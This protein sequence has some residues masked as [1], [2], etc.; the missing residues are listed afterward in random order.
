MIGSGARLSGRYP[1]VHTD[2]GIADDETLRR[3]RS[4]DADAIATLW[5]I[6]QPQVLRLLRAK[7]AIAPEDIAS[8]VWL[9][10]GRGLDR[11]RGDGTAF[12]R[13]VFTLTSRRA[14][15]ESRRR[16]RRGEISADLSGDDWCA[17]HAED[18]FD[19]GGALDRALT[20]LRRLKPATAEVV[21]LRVVHELPVAE[22]ARIT[23]RSEG[24]VRT[25]VH[26]GLGEL[27]SLCGA[28]A[29]EMIRPA[30]A[31]SIGG[32]DDANARTGPVA[33]A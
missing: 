28:D 13:W 32:P 19:A 27:R 8:D 3:A 31:H 30:G 18:D 16:R 4:G 25:I 14:I 21:M 12:R 22:V 7:Q 15:D 24:G 29:V 10:V 6:Y 1:S 11:F 9:E 23:G 26:R 17:P 33:P 20:L 5:R 2:S